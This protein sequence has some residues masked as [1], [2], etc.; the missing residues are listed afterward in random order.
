MFFD[1]LFWELLI[2]LI[3]LLV[4]DWLCICKKKDENNKLVFL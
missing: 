2:E 1:F 4:L 3:D